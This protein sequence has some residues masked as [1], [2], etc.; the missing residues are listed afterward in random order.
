[1][2]EL[3]ELEF[4]KDNLASQI[5]GK[6]IKQLQIRKPYVLKNYVEEALCDEEVEDIRRKGKYLILKLTRHEIVIHLML[7]GSIKYLLPGNRTKK[8]SAAIVNFDDGTKLEMSEI[9]HKKRMSIHI[10][11]E[12][13]ELSTFKNLGIEPMQDKFTLEKLKSMLHAKS[14]Q[15]KSFLCS[16]KKIVGIGNTYADEILWKAK[17]SPFKITTQLDEQEIDRLYDSIKDILKWAIEKIR[18]NGISGRRE[19]LHVHNKQGKPCPRCSELIQSVSLSNSET[20]YCPKCQTRGKRL[21]D[22]R[23][24]KFYR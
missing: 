4:I 7:R 14:E 16:Q 8:S 18:E 1:M 6:K 3:P 21:K 22:R 19:F 17:V 10:L 20:Y 11:R 2:P 9:G 23:M 12:H 13:K 24:S 15:L 5:I